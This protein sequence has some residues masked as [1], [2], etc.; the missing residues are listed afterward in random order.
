MA[1]TLG[2][3]AFQ[4]TD[5][6]EQGVVKR[7]QQTS[8]LMKVLPFRKINGDTYKYRV[9]EVSP[10]VSWRSVNE[11]YPES[12]GVIAPRIEELKLVGGD[13]FI[14]N[15]IKR[16]QNTGGDAIDHRATQY[17]MKARALAR[18][19]ERA[20]FEGD[21][22]IDPDEM[23]G[24]RARLTGGQVISAGTNGAAL[25][26]AMLDSLIDAVSMDVG[27]LHLFMNKTVRRKI[28]NLVNA[29][30]GSVVIN[31]GTI[32]GAAGKVA[33]QYNGIPIN[34]VEDQ[35]DFSTILG[36]DEQTGSSAVT[37]SIF[38][39]AFGEEM[40]VHGI[41]NGNGPTVDVY[42]VGET[43]LATAPGQVGRIEFYPGMC[44]KHPKAAARLRGITNA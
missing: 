35:W 16:T 2:D 3:H 17:D 43:L 38:A 11:A 36:Y 5:L 32:D 18:E 25:T 28:T 26:L 42:D 33:T 6:F 9:E 10:G 7:F 8:A 30:G 23:M 29:I 1:L 4:G 27:S 31:Y 24:L 44:I 40:G 34:V 21:P 14:D 13:V 12:T 41:Y 37:A 19:F 20:F 22:L 39:V 15:F